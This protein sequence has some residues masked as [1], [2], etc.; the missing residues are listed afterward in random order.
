MIDIDHARKRDTE[1]L[2]RIFNGFLDARSLTGVVAGLIRD[3]HGLTID[4]YVKTMLEKPDMLVLAVA[5]ELL[6]EAHED[7]IVL[8]ER[9]KN[10]E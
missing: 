7:W 1:K 4:E 6:P 9:L 8:M 3:K 10:G 5:R 2:V